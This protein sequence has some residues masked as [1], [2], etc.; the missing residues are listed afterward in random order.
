MDSIFE[1]TLHFD[2]DNSLLALQMLAE[3]QHFAPPIQNLIV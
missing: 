1:V 3:A 2:S